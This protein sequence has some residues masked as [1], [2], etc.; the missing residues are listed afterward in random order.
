MSRF[1]DIPR[2]IFLDSSCLQTL[3][4]YGPT[5]FEN[6]EVPLS[7]RIRSIPEGI[8]N[9]EALR[10]IFLVGQRAPFEFAL[11]PNSLSEVADKRDSRYLQWAFDVLNHWQASIDA[12]GLP[13]PPSSRRFTNAQFGYLSRKDALLLDDAL[14]YGCDSFLTMERRLPRNASHIL[15]S[16]GL[17]VLTP[18]GLWRLLEPWA[19]LFI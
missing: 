15:I 18:L 6:E 4:D 3:Q 10:R 17:R 12:S 19:N 11:S 7:D 9:L 1:K 8:A 2:R 14:A 5:V 16:S 13:S